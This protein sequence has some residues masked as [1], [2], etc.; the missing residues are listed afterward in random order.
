LH[1]GRTKL[2]DS[3]RPSLHIPDRSRLRAPQ[4]CAAASRERCAIAK[5]RLADGMEPSPRTSHLPGATAG[6]DPRRKKPPLE[7]MPGIDF[8]DRELIDAAA[9]LGHAT[10]TPALKHYEQRKLQIH[11]TKFKIRSIK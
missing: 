1:P 3:F 11:F 9:P 2:P 8:L 4:A 10:A 6:S 7:E 5:L